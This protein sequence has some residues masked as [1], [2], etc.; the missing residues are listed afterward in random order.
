MSE[1]LNVSVGAVVGFFWGILVEHWPWF[2]KFPPKTK[3]LGVAI[4]AGVVAVVFIAI[5]GV[6]E[7]PIPV[8]RELV[9]A[10][11]LG[12]MAGFSG[13]TVSHGVFYL[14]KENK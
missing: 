8:W 2:E 7:P 4:I 14:D 10:F 6:V 9:K 5:V 11:V 3:R 12:L 1:L 13:A